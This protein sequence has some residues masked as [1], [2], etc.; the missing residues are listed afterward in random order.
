MRACPTAAYCR[1]NVQCL[2]PQAV[3]RP[4]A[5]SEGRWGTHSRHGMLYL[6]W[7]CKGETHTNVLAKAKELFPVPLPIGGFG[8][9]HVGTFGA[10]D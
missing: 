5:C 10:M 8:E 1:V 2:R 4:A 6:V 9:E 7:K 3:C